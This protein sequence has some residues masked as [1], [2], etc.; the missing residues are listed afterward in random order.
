M[1]NIDF[2]YLYQPP[3][4]YTFD[5]IELKYW[6]EK[7]C[8]GNMVL[9]LFAGKNRLDVKEIRVDIDEK[10]PADYHIDA[11]TFV[12]N[13]NGKLFTTIVLDPPYN[14]RKAREKYGSRY[15]GK[16][17]QI[18]SIIPNILEAG[19]R[20]ISLGYDSVGMSFSRG[21]KKVAICL[22]CHG[23]DHND[24]I[25]VVEEKIMERLI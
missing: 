17:T 23:G 13:Y 19:G 22:V 5:Q 12:S 6:V 21:F 4:R 16:L 18:K 11:H 15:I 1:S 24:T 3:A 8:V 7:W 9:N 14:V 2:T 10:M 25:C 20:V